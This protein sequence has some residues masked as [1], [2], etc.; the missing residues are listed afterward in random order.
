MHA[1]KG[2]CNLRIQSFKLSPK[3]KH[4]CLGAEPSLSNS[5]KMPFF[6]LLC[7]QCNSWSSWPQEGRYRSKVLQLRISAPQPFSCQERQW[8]A[9]S[10]ALLQYSSL[11][12]MM[13]YRKDVKTKCVRKQNQVTKDRTSWLSACC[14]HQGCKL[15][16]RFGEYVLGYSHKR[17]TVTLQWELKSL[18]CKSFN[19]SWLMLTCTGKGEVPP[20][21]LGCRFESPETGA[22]TGSFPLAG[23]IL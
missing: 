3:C 22:D 19:P 16:K 15:L 5:S 21:K 12:T 13:L 4:F 2:L 17:W 6:H 9:M 1:G 23:W 11:K 14:L 18:Q 7:K 20:P 10:M 8:S